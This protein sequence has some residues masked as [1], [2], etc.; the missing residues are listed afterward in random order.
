MEET[1]ASAKEL[2]GYDKSSSEDIWI[3]I[4]VATCNYRQKARQLIKLNSALI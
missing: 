1:E 3:S 4:D 2:D